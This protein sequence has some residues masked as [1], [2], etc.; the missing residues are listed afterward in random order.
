MVYLR[1]GWF[2][3]TVSLPD[4]TTYTMQTLSITYTDWDGL[5]QT[6]WVIPSGAGGYEFATD[7][8][9][10]TTVPGYCTPP[11]GSCGV[12]G[13]I[14]YR[15]SAGNRYAASL[16]YGNGAPTVPVCTATCGASTATTTTLSWNPP[17]PTKNY[18][19]VLSA[20]VARNCQAGSICPTPSGSVSFVQYRAGTDTTICSSS[21][22]AAGKATCIWNNAAQGA[23]F[24]TFLPGNTA[25]TAGSQASGF[26]QTGDQ[27]ATTTSVTLSP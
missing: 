14:Y 1:G 4:G 2:V 23:V 18:Y 20:T 24:A 16:S 10:R 3:D 12:T 8:H 6:A 19:V 5:E 25:G 22:S 26:L 11:S 27:L 9:A 21:L 15:D 7:D 13:Q 17:I